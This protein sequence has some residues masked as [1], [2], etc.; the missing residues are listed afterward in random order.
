MLEIVNENN[1]FFS[2]K[3]GRK[4]VPKNVNSLQHLKKFPLTKLSLL[5]K[6]SV[7]DDIIFQFYNILSNWAELGR[8]AIT[9]LLKPVDQWFPTSYVCSL[10]VRVACFQCWLFE[11]H[12]LQ[13][14]GS[15]RKTVTKHSKHCG[16]MKIIICNWRLGSGQYVHT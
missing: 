3:A 8:M 7:Q 1:F 6:K 15:F 16:Y 14:L 12:F 4:I 9:L 10:Y 2:L 11:V 13:L 5:L